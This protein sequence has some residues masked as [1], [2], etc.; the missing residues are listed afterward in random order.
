MTSGASATSSSADRRVGIA[1]RPA[2]FDLDVAAVGPAQ[3]PQL[4]H[5]C[6][7][8]GLP[9][10]IVGTEIH[11]HADAS[12]ELLRV[13]GERPSESRDACQR[14]ELPPPHVGLSQVEQNI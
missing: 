3:L 12:F 9:F 10:R 13:R 14:Y 11:E 4:L 1:H 2:Y 6:A 5:E 8:P 7:Q